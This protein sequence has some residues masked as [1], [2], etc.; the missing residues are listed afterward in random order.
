MPD[1]RKAR[2]SLKRLRQIKTW[3]LLVLLLLMIFISATFL[4][5]NNIEMSQ[6]RAAVL[7]A[8]KTGDKEAVKNRLIELQRYVSAHMNANMGTLYLKEQYERDSQAAN[9]A[10]AEESVQGDIYNKVQDICAPRYAHLGRYSQAYQQCVLTEVKKY[11]QGE[12]LTSKLKLPKADNYR[13]SFVSPLWSPDFA[14]FSVLICGIIIIVI[15]GRLIGLMV[16]RLILKS[17]YRGV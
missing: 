11:P 17:R 10:A 4:R 9:A 12:N 14:G 6:R 8:D 1:K 5:L 15:I 13:H 2:L 16:L 7:A 3:Q